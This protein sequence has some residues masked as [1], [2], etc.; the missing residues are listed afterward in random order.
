GV[1]RGVVLGAPC[2]QGS[3]PWQEAQRGN[4]ARQAPARRVRF[5]RTALGVATPRRV[6][7]PAV[8]CALIAA[9]QNFTRG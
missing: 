1:C 9:R 3:D 2:R 6:S 4:T 5:W 7:N 8:G